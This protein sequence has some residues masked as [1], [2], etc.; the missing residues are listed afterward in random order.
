MDITPVQPDNVADIK[1]EYGT[2]THGEVHQT[3]VEP[4]IS[5]F[6]IMFEDQ[7]TMHPTFV[8]QG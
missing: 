2:C 4:I 3:H 7:Q 1:A 8:L 5:S 6:S